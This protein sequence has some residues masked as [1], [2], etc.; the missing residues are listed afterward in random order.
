MRFE[1]RRHDLRA[2]RQGG[3]V[4]Q[5]RSLAL[6]GHTFTVVALDGNP[7]PTP[8]RVETWW[9]GTAER[10]S[11]IVE[12]NHPGVWILGAD[13]PRRIAVRPVLADS[14]QTAVESGG[15]LVAGLAVVVD[16]THD[17]RRAY[18]LAAAH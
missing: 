14:T 15:A 16:L 12:M 5:A 6:P 13:G 3:D 2:L 9:I 1:A 10:V 4:P 8:T 18:G 7:I 17:G 11:A